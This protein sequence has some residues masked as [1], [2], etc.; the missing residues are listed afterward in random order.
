MS[1]ALGTANAPAALAA[2]TAADRHPALVYLAR[3]SPGSRR[4]MRQGLDAVARL[5]TA[6]ACDAL[7]LDWAA[8]R[9]QHTAA[10]RTRLAEA[11]APA[12]ANKVLAALRGVLKEAWRLGLMGAED[13]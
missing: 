7:T 1:D 11:Y 3:L 6:G 8:L 13:H 2:A 9:Y 4:T 10:I 5:L 12:T